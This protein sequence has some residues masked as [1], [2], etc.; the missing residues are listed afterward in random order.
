VARW[1]LIADKTGETYAMNPVRRVKLSTGLQLAATLIL[2]VCA[3]SAI[4]GHILWIGAVMFL[5]ISVSIGRLLYAA[6]QSPS[7]L[8]GHKESCD[9]DSIPWLLPE[10]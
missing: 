3:I 4:G 6:G 9:D 2:G 1:C 10:I 7:E 5:G 8:P